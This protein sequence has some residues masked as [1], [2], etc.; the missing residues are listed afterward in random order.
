MS[1]LLLLSL[2]LDGSQVMAS[3]SI[4]VDLLPSECCY[5]HDL[6]YYC[7]TPPSGCQSMA[8]ADQIIYELFNQPLWICTQLGRTWNNS[9][10][11]SRVRLWSPIRLGIILYGEWHQCHRPPT[12][13][14]DIMLIVFYHI[15]ILRS[16]S[17]LFQS[18]SHACRR[19]DFLELHIVAGGILR[20]R[21]RK[22]SLQRDH[23]ELTIQIPSGNC[24]TFK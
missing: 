16:L 8:L 14:T 24:S 3:F 12:C 9:P 15:Y 20:K 4:H 7:T 11:S 13:M 1:L 19:Q 22:T 18:A 23:F 17:F 6:H 2:A 21:K 10:K 5:T